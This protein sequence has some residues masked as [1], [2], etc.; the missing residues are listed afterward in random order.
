MR[1]RLTAALFLLIPAFGCGSAE[2]RQ[3]SP[4]D[5]QALQNAIEVRA[6][7]LEEAA[8][9]LREAQKEVQPQQPK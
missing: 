1:F 5:A 4:Q 6:K 9:L 8:K 2:K 3:S 7:A